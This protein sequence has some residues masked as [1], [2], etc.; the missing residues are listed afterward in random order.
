MP[1]PHLHPLLRATTFMYQFPTNNVYT[2]RWR[3][4]F[5]STSWAEEE[6]FQTNWREKKNV[7]SIVTGKD[8]ASLLKLHFQWVLLIPAMTKILIIKPNDN[9]GE[10]KG[11]Q[12]DQR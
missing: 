2:D 5:S 12:S 11:M 6:H 10:Y 4:K 3:D 1:V 9:T 7:R 8:R